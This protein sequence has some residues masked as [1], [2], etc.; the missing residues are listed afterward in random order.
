MIEGQEWTKGEGLGG[1]YMCHI[2]QP[3]SRHIFCD[4]LAARDT[5]H[6]FCD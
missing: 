2:L 5:V 4:K 6:G 3:L 1:A